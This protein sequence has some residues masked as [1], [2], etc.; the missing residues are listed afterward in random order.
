VP[1]TGLLAEEVDRGSGEMIGNSAF[2]LAMSAVNF[3]SP[4]AQ[5]HSEI[6]DSD[7]RDVT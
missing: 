5:G 4:G 7:H 6:T 3:A 1:H 2:T